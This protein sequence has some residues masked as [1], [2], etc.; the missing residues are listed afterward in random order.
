MTLGSP[1][2][3]SMHLLEWKPIN[4][5]KTHKNN[6]ELE[7]DIVEKARFDGSRQELADYTTTWIE[8]RTSCALGELKIIVLESMRH[9][10]VE[11]SLSL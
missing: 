5:L 3:R 9:L 11:G 8:T 7:L 1:S 6:H 2:P 4:A 10:V